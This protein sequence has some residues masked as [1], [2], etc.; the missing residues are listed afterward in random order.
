MRPPAGCI[1][2]LEAAASAGEARQRPFMDRLGALFEK[3]DRRYS[4]VADRCGFHCRGCEDSCCK[5]TFYHHTLVEY[6]YLNAGVRSL[7]K[8]LQAKIL[9]L[10]EDVLANPDAGRFCPLN[11]AGRCLLYTHRPM[12]CRLHGIAHELRR[13]D[14]SVHRGPGCAAFDSAA[15]SE[16]GIALD[17]T[18]FY[19]ELSK[20]EKEAR[21]AFG[22]S[23][24]IKM[25]ISQMVEAM[26][27]PR[28]L[29][30][31][32]FNETD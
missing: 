32:P 9:L 2:A 12:I 26:L 16:P 18:E 4:E 25:T 23:H 11:D 5:T 3:M 31:S 1:S 10:S 21:E 7:A 20:L 13:P 28:P 29:K 8:E 6:L 30:E 14:G 19:W 24:K 22:F 27:R 17:R 15:G